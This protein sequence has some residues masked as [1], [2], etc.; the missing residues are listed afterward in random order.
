M[1]DKLS[2]RAAYS[3]IT[4]TDRASGKDLPRRP[5]DLVSAGLDW[6]TPLAGLRLGAD[7]RVAGATF[8][9]RGN[10]TRLDGYGLLTLRARV[11]LGERFELYGRVENVTATDYR[12]VADYGTYGRTAFVGLRA[13]W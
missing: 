12:T 8:D 10:F 2:A 13:K 7:L 5:R 6:D 11:P 9:D 4:A 3:H 1:T